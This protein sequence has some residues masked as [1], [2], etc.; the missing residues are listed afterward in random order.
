MFRNVAYTQPATYVALLDST[1]ADGD[2]TLTT[3]G[4]EATWTGYARVLLNKAGGASPSWESVSNGV[5]QNQHAVSFGTVGASPSIIVGMAIVDGGTLNAGNVLAY[6]N[7]Q[8]VDQTP[9][10]ND[11]VQFA[12]GGLDLS[13]N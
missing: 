11:T 4:K 2:T 9:N 5:T 6:D 8:I 1:G 7:D 3:A 12:V 10:V 13:I